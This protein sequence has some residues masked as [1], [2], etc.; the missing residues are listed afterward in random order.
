MP[1]F[2][3][4]DVISVTFDVTRADLESSVGR[5]LADST[6]K[7]SIRQAFVLCLFVA[8]LVGF[9][10]FGIT[11]GWVRV[12]AVSIYG[13]SSAALLFNLVKL[14]RNPTAKV[15]DQLIVG[16]GEKT[17]LGPER[18]T[19]SSGGVSGDHAYQ[20]L[21]HAWPGV[22]SIDDDEQGVSIR[23][24]ALTSYF[25]PRRAFTTGEEMTRFVKAARQWRSGAANWHN[26]CP[27]CRYDLRGA[28]REGCP[29]CGWRREASA[30]PAPDA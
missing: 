30:A 6:A 21:R 12:V 20:T 27:K 14:G 2:D 22:E 19:I 28:N 13:L 25:I 7:G 23:T 8:L 4:P 3:S 18:V 1:Q 26:E 29:E 15:V 10:I 9:M 11:T 24:G 16:C 17:V 5:R